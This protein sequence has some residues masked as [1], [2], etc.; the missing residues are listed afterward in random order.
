MRQKLP[1]G[2]VMTIFRP[3]K[4]F[5]L[6]ETTYTTLPEYLKIGKTLPFIAKIIGKDYNWCELTELYCAKTDEDNVIHRIY[7]YGDKYIL[8]EEETLEGMSVSECGF[9]HWGIDYDC[10]YTEI[11]LINP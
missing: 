6:L 8:E 2:K 1:I 9:E 7:K 3:Q 5:F 11:S 4:P 10:W